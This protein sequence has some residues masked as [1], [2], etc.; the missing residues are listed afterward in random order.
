MST[1]PLPQDLG[2]RVFGAGVV[3]IALVN[4]VLGNFDSAQPVPASFPGRTA[5]AYASSLFILAA[6]AGILCR[7][8][9]AWSAGALAAYYFF[10][11]V[12]LMNGRV[13]ARHSGE[14]GAY[15]SA[16]AELALAA[17]ALILYSASARLERT[18]AAR[19]AYIGRQTF[20]IC[21]L[22]F[23]G[24]HCAYPAMTIPLVP[25]WLPPSQTFWA[26]ATAVFHIAA[27]VAIL[28]GLK[29]RLAAILL[30]VMYAAFTPLVHVPLL[31][32]DPSRQFF[33]TENVLNLALVGVAWVVA[34]SLARIGYP[35]SRT[36]DPA[37]AQAA[38]AAPVP[39]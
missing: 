23:G 8:F 6:G 9:V 36:G 38:Q 28:T 2:A 24:A 25:A 19:L 20:G 16:A 30:A 35:Q 14:F 1:T 39:W 13:I 15:S 32:S 17:A 31:L 10:V 34:D 4:L 5:L 27:G 3:A 33:W 22:L 37:S 12:V 29:P 18:A 11:V 21:A 7:R 26:Y